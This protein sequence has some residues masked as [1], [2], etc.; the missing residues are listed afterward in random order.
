LAGISFRKHDGQDSRAFEKL[1]ALT[2]RAFGYEWNTYK[3]TSSEED[4]LT[5][6]WLTGADPS[7]YGKIPVT[8]VF[9]Y[10]P[11][12]NQIVQINPDQI[13][14]K[15]VLEVG[16]GMGKYVKVVSDAAAE[17]IGM[18]LSL[19]LQ[20]ARQENRDRSNVHFVQ[21]DILNPPLRRQSMDFVYSVGVLHHTPDCHRAFQRCASLV[22]PGGALAVWL[23]PADPTPDNYA[24]WVH[25]L[26][27]DFLRP[28]TCRMPLWALRLI[29]GGLGRLTFTRD[30][31]VER[32][33]ATGS[34]WARRV[35]MAAG[36]VA[37]GRHR[38]PE[39]AAFLN[40]DWYSPQYRSYHTEEQ[41][42]GW[43]QSAGFSDVRILPQRVS[44]IGH[45]S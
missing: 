33:H 15:R 12:V 39:I 14:G 11:T 36:A 17:V 25:W 13:A 35:A 26:Q 44:G 9:T 31:F 7:V 19:S 3:T 30:H 24:K 21:G 40:F 10:Y 38:D 27:D 42:L 6:Y 45:L 1:H 2:A 34:R 22:A 8:D 41:L 16:C 29:C 32:Y 37:V 20:R 43:F 5:F 18:D 4:V 23:Y 28:I